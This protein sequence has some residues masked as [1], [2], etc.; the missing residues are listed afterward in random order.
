MK[1]SVEK[2]DDMWRYLAYIYVCREC[3]EPFFKIFC[4]FLFICCFF[5]IFAI[6]YAIILMVSKFFVL[7]IFNVDTNHV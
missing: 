1:V 7:L 3:F 5:C 2:N 6:E 4:M